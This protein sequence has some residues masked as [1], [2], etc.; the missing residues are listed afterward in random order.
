MDAKQN[1]NKTNKQKTPFFYIQETHLNIKDRY[2]FR[3]KGYI[4]KKHSKHTD[5]RS[6]L[7]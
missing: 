5:L 2:Y 1:K 7:I 6:K 4:K 3:I